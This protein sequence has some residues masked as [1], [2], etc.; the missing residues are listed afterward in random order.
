MKREEVKEEIKA[1]ITTI[2][3]KGQLE[4]LAPACCDSVSA[5]NLTLPS[6]GAFLQLAEFFKVF[7]DRTR[8]KILM[9]LGKQEL[10]VH[11]IAKLLDVEQSVVSH[12]LKT[13]RDARI[14]YS[15][16][17][18]KHIFYRLCDVHIATIL[19]TAMEHIQEMN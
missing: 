11:T 4:D 13:L 5:E 12:Q 8:L 1:P 18:G 6:D 19:D 9:L 2:Q 7:G 17:V 14:V 10:C 3:P 15:R 16:R